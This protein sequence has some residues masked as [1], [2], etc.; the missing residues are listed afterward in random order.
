M[1]LNFKIFILWNYVVNNL[2]TV[3]WVR[4]ENGGLL[5][6]Q[7]RDLEFNSEFIHEVLLVLL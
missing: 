3:L 6:F 5:H 1:S 4:V 7:L 2:E